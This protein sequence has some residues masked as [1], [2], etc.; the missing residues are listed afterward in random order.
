MADGSDLFLSERRGA[1]F[2]TLYIDSF[3]AILEPGSLAHPSLVVI[4]SS[5]RQVRF[6]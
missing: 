3:L 5:T 6:V 2:G 1:G 4:P